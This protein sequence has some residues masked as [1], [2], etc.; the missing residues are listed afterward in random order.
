MHRLS[1]TYT[2]LAEASISLTRLRARYAHEIVTKLR[3]AGIVWGNS[4]PNSGLVDANED[5]WLI[6][7][8]SAC[9]EVWVFERVELICRGAESASAQY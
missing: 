5:A 3:N 4:K 8:S 1:R 6:D 9:S 7:F 2:A